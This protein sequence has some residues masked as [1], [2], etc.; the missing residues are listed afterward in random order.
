[1]RLDPERY[2][3]ACALVGHALK[4]A[5]KIVDAEKRL[6]PL[7]SGLPACETYSALVGAVLQAILA[8]YRARDPGGRET[9]EGAERVPK[10]A[11]ARE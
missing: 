2:E 4:S 6:A 10:A 5:C 11:G 1:M 7:C 9:T 8:D 3:A